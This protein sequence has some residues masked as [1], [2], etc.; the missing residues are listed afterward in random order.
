MSNRHTDT[1]PLAQARLAGT[2]G[3]AILAAGT[4]AGYVSSALVV[5]GNA[6]ATADNILTSETWFRLG[7]V[8]G[9]AMYVIFVL[10]AV[11]LHGLLE[12]V[13]RRHALVMLAL[14]LVGVPI[15]MLNQV[16]QSAALLL[17]DGGGPL[18]GVSPEQVH[19]QVMVFLGLHR[20]GNVVAVIFWGLWLF[21]LG[22]LV[23]RSGFLPRILGVALMIGCFGWLAVVFQRFLLPDFEALAGA[24]YAAHLA[25][26]S[27]IAWLLVKGVDVES[28]RER[29]IEADRAHDLRRG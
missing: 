28:W 27:F 23:Y 22:L 16:H 5:P 9:L 8:S 25:E 1:S 6:A 12:K 11:V 7:L 18:G 2:L 14:A 29:A 15:A 4:F 20:H 17:L 26:L 10:Y 3:L 21:P 24:R 19:A 13:N